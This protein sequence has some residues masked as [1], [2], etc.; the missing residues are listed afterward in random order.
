MTRF[1]LPALAIGFLAIG[2]LVAC[3]VE[4]APANSPPSTGP[5]LIEAT[6]AYHDPGGEWPSLRHGLVI[7][8][9]RPDGSS[10][11][12]TVRLDVPQSTFSHEE[13]T[14]EGLV[15]KG[16]TGDGCFATVDGR[17]PTEEQVTSLRLDCPAIERMRNYHLYLWGLPMKL[18]DPG[19]IIDPVIA[20]DEFDGRATKVVK[21]TYDAEVGTD[22]WYFHFDPSTY[23]MVGYQ[24]YHDETTG[25]GEYILLSGERDVLGMKIPVERRWFTNA[26]DSYLGTD[27]LVDDVPGGPQR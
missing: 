2:F 13:D 26:E 23:R 10:R 15:A 8:Q 6:I 24:F 1:R 16:V 22:T 4:S 20:D 7:D 5:E 18:R 21:V 27:V 25:R 11:R 3:G 12:A 9:S 17:Q 14:G 19:T